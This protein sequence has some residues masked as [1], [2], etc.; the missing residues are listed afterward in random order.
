MVIFNN[1]D[2]KLSIEEVLEK[3]KDD[4]FFIIQNLLRRSHLWGNLYTLYR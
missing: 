2:V 1:D 3:L 4:D